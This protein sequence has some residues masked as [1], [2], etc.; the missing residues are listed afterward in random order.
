MPLTA[1]SVATSS[2]SQAHTI[3]K[4]LHEPPQPRTK[5]IYQRHLSKTNFTSSKKILADNTSAKTSTRRELFKE[6]VLLHPHRVCLAK[7]AGAGAGAGAGAEAEAEL[8]LG[9]IL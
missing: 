2:S 7:W 8:G 5:L 6:P 4:M 3:P 9:L 1:E